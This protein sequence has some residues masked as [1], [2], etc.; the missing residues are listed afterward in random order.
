MK[1]NLNIKKYVFVGAAILCLSTSSCINDLDQNPIIDKG[2][3]EIINESDCQ[4]FLAKIYSG[5]G[6]SGNVGPSGGVQ[7]LQGPD[8]GSLCF[9]R[10]LLSLELYPTDEALWN[11]KDEGIVELC[12]NNWD[13]TLFY[14]YTFYQRAML[15]IRY[16]KEFLDNY[17]EDCGI[18]NIKQFR[19]EVRA[20]HRDH[21]KIVVIDGKVGYTGG[22]NIANYYIKG[23]PEIGDWRDM[24]VRIEGDAV[25]NLQDIFLTMW[26]KSTKQHIG[27]AMYYPLLN[28]SIETG[29][30]TV[31]IVDRV[32]RKSPKIMRRM[33]VKSLDAAQHKVQIVN[34]YFTPTHSIKKAIRRA[35]KRGVEVEIMIP[36]KSD[37]PFTPD[38]AFYTS[39]KLRKKGAEI[40]IYNGG[41][42]HSK[43]MMVD[44]LFCTVGSTNLNSRSL[45][46]DYEVNA[47]IFDKETTHELS[48]MFEDDKKDSTLLTKEEYKKRSAW[49][50]FVGWFANM[51]TP[52]L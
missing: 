41:F 33:Y 43:I 26:N 9:L 44:S 34:P 37:I 23:L 20:L 4:S 15:N 40:Y 28:D 48:S 10:G 21:R 30:K 35:L 25:N 11:W 29:G 45:R 32:P 18:P 17:P 47:F 14:A 36:G 2:Q 51:F 8:Q 7:D 31:A 6:L 12:T 38:A 5:F 3:S 49:K 27:G 24:H 13:Y 19:D 42:H 46:Y 16:C 50:R 22:M 1:F 39:N 52:F